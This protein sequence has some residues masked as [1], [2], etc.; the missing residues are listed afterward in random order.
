MEISSAVGD[1]GRDCSGRASAIARASSRRGR[2]ERGLG[3]T[4]VAARVA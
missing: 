3:G 2:T 1:A 4:R